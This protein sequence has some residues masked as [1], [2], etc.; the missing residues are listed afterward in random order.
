MQEHIP[1]LVKQKAETSVEL[2]FV[3]H[4]ILDSSVQAPVRSQW[5]RDLAEVY[6]KIEEKDR[7][8]IKDSISIAKG[9][10]WGTIVTTLGKNP[11]TS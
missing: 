4:A 6:D 11:I 2:S 5:L 3:L 9:M 1:D 10:G 8:K 7:A